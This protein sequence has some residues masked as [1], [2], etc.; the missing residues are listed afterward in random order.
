LA[1]GLLIALFLVQ[2]NQGN[3]TT[4]AAVVCAGG[5]FPCLPGDVVDS[6][7]RANGVGLLGPNRYAILPFSFSDALINF[8]GMTVVADSGEQ[9]IYSWGTGR[10]H[11][12]PDRC[13]R[14]PGYRHYSKLCDPTWELGLFRDERRWMQCRHDRGW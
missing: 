1:L 13:C 6:G 3:A 2:P 8:S 5:E 9:F 11:R 12:G 10:R 4:V 14:V 7:F